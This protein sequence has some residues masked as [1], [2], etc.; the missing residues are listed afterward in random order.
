L[1]EHI[2]GDEP[3][4]TLLPHFLSRIANDFP[5]RNVLNHL[6]RVV[7]EYPLLA[8]NLDGLGLFWLREQ[9]SNVVKEILS[10]V[11]AIVQYA[12]PTDTNS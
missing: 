4:L 1:A 8:S 11:S 7:H 6:L 10:R 5:S 2:S 3:N 12:D 9:A